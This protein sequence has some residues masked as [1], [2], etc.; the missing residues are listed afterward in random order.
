MRECCFLSSQALEEAQQ[1]IQQLFSRIIDIKEKAD[2]SEQMVNID[3]VLFIN[4]LFLW[5]VPVSFKTGLWVNLQPREGQQV[6]SKCFS[7]GVLF[8][9]GKNMNS[10]Q[11]QCEHHN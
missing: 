4:L 11:Q 2:K 5:N 6:T 8:K 10:V 7:R 1:A 9:I 3:M